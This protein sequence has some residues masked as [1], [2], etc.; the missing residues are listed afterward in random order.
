M[1]FSNLWGPETNPRW[2]W[3]ATIQTGGM[4]REIWSKL[5]AN[6]TEI[7]TGS[8]AEVA[9]YCLQIVCSKEKKNWA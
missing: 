7:L 8:E 3:D 1:D 6:M 2:H 4:N 5:L 9:A